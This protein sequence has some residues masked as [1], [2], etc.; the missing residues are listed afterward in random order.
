MAAIAWD[1]TCRLS[2]VGIPSAHVR[3]MGNRVSAHHSP[4]SR[5]SSNRPQPIATSQHQR[6]RSSHHATRLPT[7]RGRRHRPHLCKR[8][9]C[10]PG[11]RHLPHR[12]AYRRRH[13]LHRS[14]SRFAVYIYTAANF[15]LAMSMQRRT[16]LF[17]KRSAVICK[18]FFARNSLPSLI[19]F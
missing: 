3:P 7:T 16:L 10:L 4:H 14:V 18:S 5:S 9:I 12:S 13:R 2:S 1:A 6:P 15:R 19:V 17:P 8:S 11:F